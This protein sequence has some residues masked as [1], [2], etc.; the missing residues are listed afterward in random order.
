V[1]LDEDYIIK[2]PRSDPNFA[3]AVKDIIEKGKRIYKEAAGITGA[4]DS[5]I[6][7]VFRLTQ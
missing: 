5:D 4:A 1:I 3:E 6:G 2:I 7:V